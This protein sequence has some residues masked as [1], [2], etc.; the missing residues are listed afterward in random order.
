MASIVSLLAP[1]YNFPTDLLLHG[2]EC[3]L[4]L[5]TVPQSLNVPNA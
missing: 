4:T 3:L 5:L 2:E 1:P